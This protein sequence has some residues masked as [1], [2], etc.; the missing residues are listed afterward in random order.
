MNKLFLKLSQ[1]NKFETRLSLLKNTSILS[2]PSILG[3]LIALVSIPIHLNFNSKSD[4]GN[5]I[6]FHFIF[7][8]GLLLNFGLNKIT[9]IELAQKKNI[10]SVI[11][12]SLLFSS[13]IFCI[14]LI[15]S[16]SSSFFFKDLNYLLTISVG[17]G[18]TIIYITLEGILQGIKKF[19]LLSIGNFIF[20]TLSLNIP[21]LSL[22]LF[23]MDFIKLIKISIVIKLISI[24]IIS[25]YLRKYFFLKEKLNYN[26]IS[27]LRKYSKWY[28]LH[29]LN[30]QIYDF[31]DKY[32]INFFIG[33]IALAIYSIP[34]QLAGKITIF[35]K[36][37]A[38][39][40]LPEISSGNERKNFDYSLNIYTFVVPLVLLTIFPFLDKLLFFWLNDEYS[41]QILNLTK[42]FLI[43]SWISGISHILIAFFEGKKEIRF[44]TILEISFIIPF[45]IC[46]VLIL[47]SFKNLL[48]ISFIL[49]LKEYVLFV[50]RSNKLQKN[51][52]SLIDIYLNV[53]FVILILFVSINYEQFFYIAMFFLVIFNVIVLFKKAYR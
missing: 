32:L 18:I 46:L 35:S 28:F 49:L 42:V 37:I 24:I 7:S 11:K 8:F 41:P 25:V 40:L 6:F 44:N 5:Y 13:F 17:I 4:Y 26:F 53:L 30:I 21:S 16:F 39:V 43:I 47:F 36:S 31:I 50:V 15:L 19:K 33:P 3:I 14:L 10:S 29:N 2:L 20:H 51:I 22:F 52:K 9:V 23:E 48:Y 12:K 1:L 34:Y 27:K 45:L 38:A